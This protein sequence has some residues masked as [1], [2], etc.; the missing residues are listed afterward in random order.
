MRKRVI[1]E[2]AQ[3]REVARERIHRLL[4]LAEDVPLERADRYAALARRIS[5]RHR[6]RMPRGARARICRGCGGHLRFGSTARVRLT[7]GVRAVTCL[8]C[9]HVYRMP[10]P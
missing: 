6:I 9:G 8:R 4:E 7:E 3:V 2:R 1:R 5:Q 10:Y